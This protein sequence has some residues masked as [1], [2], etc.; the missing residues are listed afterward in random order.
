MSD[1]PRL[2]ATVL[3][4]RDDPLRV[5]MV[6]RSVRGAF[7][8]ALVFPGGV[9]ERGDADAPWLPTLDSPEKWTEAERTVR[10]AAVREV[11]EE[12]GMVIAA[13]SQ[14]A[15]L[16]TD[17]DR[18]N[19]PGVLRESDVVLHLDRLVPFGNWVTPAGL[20]RRFDT[21]FFLYADRSEHEVVI[22][23]QEIV[24]HEWVTP[25]DMI[26]RARSGGERVLF[27]TLATLTQ[28]G[29]HQSI[30]AAIEQALARPLPRVEPWREQRKDGT[31]V[32]R[33]PID[34]GYSLSELPYPQLDSTG[35]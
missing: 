17:A 20:A 33:I 10:I 9:V 23:G 24:D 25:S 8:S 22:D 26:D 18:A 14:L 12:V 29:Q 19:L 28:L 32:S 6:K 13:E 3:V 31:S 11:Y 1:H 34:A 21:H 2:A 35:L 5:L 4:V 15:T 27:P 16:A 30:D 7:P